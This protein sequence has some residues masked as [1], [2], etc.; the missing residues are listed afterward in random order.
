MSL[1]QG[2]PARKPRRLGLWAPFVLTLVAVVALGATWVDR[3]SRIERSMDA[4]RQ[5]ATSAGWTLTWERRSIHGFPFRLDVELDGVRVREPSGWGLAAAHLSAEAFVFSPTHWVAVAPTGVVIMLHRGG[6]IRVEAKALRASFS[7]AE[8]SPPRISVE[9]LDMKFAALPESAPFLLRTAHALHI[10]TKSGPD[11]QGAI[12]IEIDG[13]TAE[14][15]S[16]IG[17]L[18]AARQS[19]FVFDGLFTRARSLRGP[20]QPSA[21]RAWSAAGGRLTIRHL[22]VAAGQAELAAN[23]GEIGVGADGRLTG[24]VNL[25]L[26]QAPKTLAAMALSGTLP[27]ETARAAGVV[28][29]ARQQGRVTRLPLSFQAGRMTFGPVALGSSPRVY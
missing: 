22:R 17:R 8:A 19:D 25:V 18:A 11:D 10:H 7:Y 12:Y 26:H 15:D 29:S 3:K 4:A 2:A 24:S 23:A 28:V 5:R 6:P 14:P 16:L 27:P 20:D 13:A 21:V 1:P 9:G